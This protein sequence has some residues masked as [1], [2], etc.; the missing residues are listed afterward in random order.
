MSSR[1]DIKNF[2]VP[3]DEA[4]LGDHARGQAGIQDNQ[5]EA[6]WGC[7]RDPSGLIN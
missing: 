5:G 3:G 4:M 1:I 7:S 2:L 6:D